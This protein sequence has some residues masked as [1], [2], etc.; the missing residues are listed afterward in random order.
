M[1]TPYFAR[2]FPPNKER[3][4]DTSIPLTDFSTVSVPTSDNELSSR[5]LGLVARWVP[6]ALRYY[7]P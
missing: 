6:V 5:F 1:V 3:F 4:V 7:Q 2:I